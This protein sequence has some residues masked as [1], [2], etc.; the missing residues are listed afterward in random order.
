MNTSRAN[1]NSVLNT[2][3]AKNID[4]TAGASYQYQ[5]NH[6]Y[7]EVNDLLGGDFY[8]DLNQFAE[9]DFATDPK[10]NQNDLNRPN[11]ILKVGDE[12]GYNY[13]INIKHAAAWMQA[14]VKFR[15][16]DFFL[17]AEHS[18]T[19]FFRNG[20]TQVGLF[21]E[22]SYGKSEKQNFYNYT[23]K[24]GVTYKID[25]RN[26]LFANGA[27]MT[28]APF[29]ENA[30]VAPRTRD[31]VQDNL[32]SERIKSVEAGYVMNAPKLKLRLTGYYT[33]FA[34][35]M[36]VLTFYH[37]E[38]RN[39]VNYAISGI[40]KTHYGVE[41]GVDAK[42][43]KGL[44]LNAGASVGDFRFNS[45]QNATVTVD[46]SAT[47]VSK[48]IIYSENYKVPTAQQAYTIGL[49]YRSPRFWFLNVNFN[50]FDNMWLDFNPL[51]RTE[52][53]VSGVDPSTQ[54]WQDITA[55]EQLKAQYTVDAFAGYSWLMNNKFKGLKKR[56]F[57]VFNV[58]VNNLLNNT[59]IVSGGFEQLRFDFAGKNVNK[60]PARK[61]YSYGVNY[62]A[63]IGLR[64]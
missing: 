34:D 11:R 35:Q 17:A 58:G 55:Q 32:V 7:K 56:H 36:N 41:F 42:I 40:N 2:S 13:D 50:Y 62:F 46:N 24:G 30:F 61:F 18:Y 5:K 20:R 9:R 48:E 52:S 44:S 27:Y 45:R 51:R 38:F 1:V 43:Y 21:P 3:I 57:L 49:D 15:K 8:V 12:F 47:L 53:A 25:G 14:V 31:I 59:D 4:F 28:R 63:S 54:L 23:F 37:D 33:D 39:F 19:Q 6:Y 10:A 60:F 16:I 26:Y 64:F 22:N 29:F